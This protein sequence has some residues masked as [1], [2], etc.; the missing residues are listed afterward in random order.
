MKNKKII[1]KFMFA[2]FAILLTG[3][4]ATD[5]DSQSKQESSS[6]SST[7]EVSIKE[8]EHNS[9]G[10]KYTQLLSATNWQG[11]KVYDKDNNDLTV[12][13]A[14]FIGLAKYDQATGYYEFYDKETGETRGDEGTF[15]ITNDGDKRVLISKTKNY[16]AIVDLTE[17]TEKVFTYKRMGKDKD[18]KE[19]EVFVEHIPY[20]DTELAFT[21]GREK[22]EH[23]TGTINKEVPGIDILGS[24]LWNGTKVTDEN[25]ND[26]TKENAM[27]ISLA[28]FDPITN[29]YEFYDKE[30]GETK[31]DFGYFDV[32]DDNKIRAHVS[33]G[34]NKYGAV[35]ELSELND[36]RF[37]YKRQG[38]DKKGSDITIFVEHEPYSGELTPDFTF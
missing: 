14:E 27:F 38:K 30:T 34:E 28:K 17:M 20:N 19:I 3:C 26:V 35:L 37:T 16:Q 1:S 25:G 18:G 11:T 2:T 21:N 22:L 12:E 4:G 8:D 33:I 9:K 6:Q 13:N 36:Q 15:F 7:T 29:K 23:S 32:L 31:G 5:T 24:T 10:K